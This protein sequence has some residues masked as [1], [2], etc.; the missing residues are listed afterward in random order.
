MKSVA[1]A[2]FIRFI[3]GNKLCSW[4]F[5]SDLSLVM[6]RPTFCI[7]ENKGAH[8]QFSAFV[9]ATQIERF[10]F[11]LN[12]KFQVSS[13]LLWL[14]SQVGVE[15]GQKPRRQVFS[16]HVIYLSDL[17]MT[18]LLA[19]SN[20]LARFHFFRPFFFYRFLSQQVRVGGRNKNKNKIHSDHFPI[21]LKSKET[22]VSFDFYSI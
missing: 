10:L 7:S 18:I 9:F 2:I 14:Y 1:I 21:E 22:R 16:C 13:H 17:L 3:N 4:R 19:E 15:P 6:R 11:F 20:N 5:M 8:Q 12:A